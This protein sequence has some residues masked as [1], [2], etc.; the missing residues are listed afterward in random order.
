MTEAA[1]RGHGIDIQDKHFDSNRDAHWLVFVNPRTG[2]ILGDRPY[3]DFMQLT[4][5]FHAEL[6]GPFMGRGYLGI[7]GFT[8][9]FLSIT[10]LVYWWPKVGRWA[11]AFRIATDRG[12]NRL[13]RDLHTV[14]GAVIA[15]ALILSSFTGVFMCYE[16]VIMTAFRAIGFARATSP[17]LPSH[18]TQ[19]GREISVGAAVQAAERAFP[20]YF[21]ASIVVPVAGSHRYL[22]EMMPLHKSR[23][24]WTGEATIDAATGQ[25]LG[26]FDPRT[27][28]AGNSIVL[29]VIF[30]HNGQMFGWP[31]RLLVMAEG[32]AL[33]GLCVTGPWLWLIR[34]RALQSRQPRVKAEQTALAA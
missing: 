8:I 25:I 29:W 4:Y 33:A 31:G 6:L 14:S 21:P 27:Q 17:P 30:F 19:Q 7:I 2:E 16:A 34:R 24:W 28:P 12:G 13:L 22:V 1:S 18:A 5:W 15:I 3:W 32:L 23:I 11:A 26:A 9:L 20:G 10:G